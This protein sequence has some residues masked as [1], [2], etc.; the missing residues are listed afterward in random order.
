M[1]ELINYYTSERNTQILIYLMKYHGIRKVV[2]SPGTTNIALVYSIQHDD[3]FEV[4]SAPDERSA[5]YIAC[6][7]AAETKEPVAISCTGATASRNYIS[8]LTEAFYRKL[9]ILAITS[10]Q[11]EG[12]IGHNMPQVIDRSNIQNDIAVMSVTIPIVNTPEEE[13]DSEIKINDA[14]LALKHHGGGPVHI[15]L[16]TVYSKDFSVKDLPPA[17]VINRITIGDELP[18]LNGKKIAIFVGAHDRWDDSL[19]KMADKFCEKYNAVVLCDHTS[20]YKGK[21]RVLAPIIFKRKNAGGIFNDFDVII[22]LG[23]VSGA[24]IPRLKNIKE[25]W[26]VN[27][28]GKICDTFRKLRYVFEMKE[29]EFFKK[30]SEGFSSKETENHIIEKWNKEY[31]HILKNI[32]EVP[33]SNIWVAHKTSMRLPENAVLHLGILNSLRSWNYFEVPKSVLGYSNTGGFGIDGCVSSLIGASLADKNRLFFGVVGDLAF[34][35]D[36]NS[37]ANRH[38]GSNLRLMVINNG[39]GAEFKVNTHMAYEFGKETDKFIAASGHYGNKSESLV[40]HYAESLGFEYYSA[41]DKE[42]Y[43]EVLPKFVQEDIT[44]K[45]IIVEIFTEYEN[46]SDALE[47]IRSTC[48]PSE[49]EVQKIEK[50]LIK[51]DRYKTSDN[52]ECVVVWGAG[53]CFSE[54]ISIVQKECEVKY[55]CDNN[56]DKW[57]EEIVPGVK[58]I[59]PKELQEM[60][61][62]FVIIMIENV[63]VAFQ[64][65]NQLLDMGISTFDYY[66]NWLR[67][68]D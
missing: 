43:L 23:N 20:N 25:V 45:P 29:E 2:A 8:G 59:S 5:A 60:Q 42:T 31:N 22:H 10:T 51:P 6:G 21:Y 15:N 34:F 28:D 66:F 44:D 35:Y 7:L 64:V 30:Y 32:P 24:Y 19:E 33:F 12:R 40:K 4:Y 14:L 50:K 13:W 58:C 68:A 67:Y 27:E 52:K 9:P 1:N 41:S 55:V 56:A 37:I 48:A 54:N 47:M 17:R 65:A 62:V 16:T 18:E 38:V 11:Y 36:M 49:I 46:E 53:K 39:G 63:S 3:Y 61:D 57:G 26:R